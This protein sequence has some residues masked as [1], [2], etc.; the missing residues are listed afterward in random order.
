VLAY[1]AAAGEF[2]GDAARD[3]QCLREW[4]RRAI[5]GHAT[6]RPC[7]AHFAHNKF[8]PAKVF[9]GERMRLM[10]SPRL[11]LNHAGKTARET[12]KQNL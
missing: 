3:R 11:A 1:G 9:S 8:R 4:C 6:L 10:M 5:L 2:S 7:T 12:K